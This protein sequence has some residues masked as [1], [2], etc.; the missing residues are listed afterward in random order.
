MISYPFQVGILEDNITE[1]SNDLGV[2]RESLLV[3]DMWYEQL[4]KYDYHECHNHGAIGYSACLYVSF[5]NEEHLATKFHGPYLG[6]LNGESLFFQPE[7]KEGDIIFFPSA[8]NHEAPIN[9]SDETRI[10]ISFNIKSP[11]WG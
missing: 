5:N 2:S 1:F 4:R 11:L 9:I 10:V 3:R 8:L 6:F 7:V